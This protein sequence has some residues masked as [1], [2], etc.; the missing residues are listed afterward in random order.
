MDDLTLIEEHVIR[1]RPLPRHEQAIRLLTGA[2]GPLA[3]TASNS[4]SSEVFTSEV[5]RLAYILYLSRAWGYAAG[6]L[7]G[8]KP[9]DA[10]ATWRSRVRAT[11]DRVGPLEM[12]I[13]LFARLGVEWD[14]T[15]ETDRRW[16][17]VW[18]HEMRTG[19]PA[20]GDR[21]RTLYWHDLQRDDAVSEALLGAQL[22]RDW[23]HALKPEAPPASN[24]EAETLSALNTRQRLVAGLL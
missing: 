12:V 22:L 9:Q 20:D 10:D 15:G 3:P 6:I 4:D 24:D 5:A 14:A 16:L 21:S 19:Q 13:D 23:M 8:K 18:D 11:I 17:R 7:G 2:I 1:L